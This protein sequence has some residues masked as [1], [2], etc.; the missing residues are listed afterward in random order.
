M[1]TSLGA[2]QSLSGSQVVKVILESL[3]IAEEEE[4]RWG[5]VR[6][7]QGSYCEWQLADSSMRKS[8]EEGLARS[9]TTKIDPHGKR[10][11]PVPKEQRSSAATRITPTHKTARKAPQHW[12]S[13]GL[14]RP[15]PTHTHKGELLV[16]G[17]G[18]VSILAGFTGGR[19]VP[20]H[21][22]NSV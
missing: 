12:I 16:W 20:S 1:E 3:Q 2:Y 22:V 18:T 21:T 17:T 4:S 8:V 14:T 13:Y 15:P 10:W 5:A 11:I 6:E 9:R 7:Q 19:A